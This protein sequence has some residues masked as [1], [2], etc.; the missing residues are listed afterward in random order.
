MRTSIRDL[1]IVLLISLILCGLSLIC[2]PLTLLT[3]TLVIFYIS[4]EHY[5]T[6]LAYFSEDGYSE[7]VC[8]FVN[9]FA[10]VIMIRSQSLY[11]GMMKLL[12]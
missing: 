4:D 11:P 8:G 3:T 5:D 9:R 2:S 12:I 10:Q 1:N 6:L 7:N